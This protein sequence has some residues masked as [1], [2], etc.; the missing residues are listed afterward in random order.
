MSIHA[1]MLI[2]WFILLF[3]ALKTFPETLR[4]VEQQQ[5]DETAQALSFKGSSVHNYLSDIYRIRSVI[6]Y[7]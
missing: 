4:Q 1:S 5:T 3:T 6:F 7:S 2:N